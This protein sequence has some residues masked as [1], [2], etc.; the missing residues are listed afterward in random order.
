ML[1]PLLHGL[2]LVVVPLGVDAAAS[3][4]ALE[5]EAGRRVD[6]RREPTGDR[7]S[8]EDRLSAVRYPELDEVSVPAGRPVGTGTEPSAEPPAG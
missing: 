1:G 8:V 6:Q 2:P 4:E 5:I 7:A 3:E